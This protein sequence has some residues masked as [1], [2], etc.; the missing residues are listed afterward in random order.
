MDRVYQTEEK[1]YEAFAQ[2]LTA[3]SSYDAERHK[4]RFTGMDYRYWFCRSW[5]LTWR[6]L[7]KAGDNWQQLREE[8]LDTVQEMYRITADYPMDYDFLK[9][10]QAYIIGRKLFRTNQKHIGLGPYI[11]A[12]GD[13]VTVFFGSD[14]PQVL[15][16]VG[17]RFRF[18]GNCY[19]HGIMNGE[20]LEKGKIGSRTFELV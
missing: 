2:V 1:R 3:G 5:S 13:I 17:E 10:A 11:I 19:I 18:L 14:V 6:A 15:R 12:P 4:K 7:K 20:T 9:T 8:W 16:P